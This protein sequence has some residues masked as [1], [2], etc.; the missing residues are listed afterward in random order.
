MAQNAYERV[1]SIFN[2]D[3]IAA[4]TRAVY[5]RVWAEYKASSWGES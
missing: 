5:E 3:V 4:D 2:W 1:E